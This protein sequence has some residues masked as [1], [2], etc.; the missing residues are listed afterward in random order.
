MERTGRGKGEDKKRTSLAA[1][2]DVCSIASSF[3]V[4]AVSSQ[5]LSGLLLVLS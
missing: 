2:V 1:I 5:V 3:I 4:I